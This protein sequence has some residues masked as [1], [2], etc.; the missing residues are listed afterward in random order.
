MGPGNAGDWVG[1]YA[2]GAAD[3]SYVDWK[4]LNG[5][6]TKPGGGVAGATVT[7]TLP[8]TTGTYNV[9]FFLNDSSFKLAT[10]ATIATPSVT[11]S[12]TSAALGGNVTATIADGPGNAGDWVGLYAAGAADSTYVDWK[13]LNG[14]RTKP[15]AGMTGATVTLTLPATTGT[16]NVRFFLNDSTLKLGTSETITVSASSNIAL[17]ATTVVPGG[18]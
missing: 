3:S 13:Y 10:S 7:F 16:Y 8:V 15:G 17:S 6:R 11:A 18:T 5:T 12:P 2:A 4:Y 9:R 14:T 1:L